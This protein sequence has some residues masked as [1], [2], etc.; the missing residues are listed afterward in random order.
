M[1]EVLVSPDVEAAAVAYLRAGLG[2]LADKVATRV[3]AV[4]PN[5]PPPANMV[6]VSLTGGSRPRL[7]QDTAQLTVEC[8]SANDPTASL[9]ARTAHAYMLAA[10]GT[11]AGGVFVRKVETVGGV[12][13]FPDPDTN[14][15]R[16]Q[17]TVR[18]HVRPASI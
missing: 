8:W 3:P 13:Y 16:Y 18:W 9:L 4:V 5:V 11:T 14:K 17:F 12:Q 2:V 15:P 10:S 1:A 7:V 6:K